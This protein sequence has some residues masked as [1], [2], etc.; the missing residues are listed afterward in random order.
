MLQLIMKAEEV[1][2]TGARKGEKDLIMRAKE[3]QHIKGHAVHKNL[4]KE[5]CT[6][7]KATKITELGLW[8][9]KTS[10]RGRPILDEVLTCLNQISCKY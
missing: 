7:E 4:L 6:E 2:F 8:C 5:G 10:P 3:K 9:A 1:T